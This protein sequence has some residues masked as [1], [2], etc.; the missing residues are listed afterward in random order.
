MIVAPNKRFLSTP[1]EGAIA[2]R[3]RRS[4]V[5]VSTAFCTERGSVRCE[6]RIERG[7]MYA[8][9]RRA[10]P[11][12]HA[13]ADGPIAPRKT[14]ILVLGSGWGAV[15]FVKS[16]D[17][18][19]FGDE[20]AYE[21]VV[22]SPRDYFVYTPL[23]PAVAS[24]TVD[25]ASIT[26]PMADVV[27]GKGVFVQATATKIDADA[28]L[29]S[30]EQRGVQ[31]FV[32]PEKCATAGECAISEREHTYALDLA[33]DV[34]VAAVGA[35]TSTYGIPGV[36]AHC[37]SIRTAE[38]SERL[39]ARFTASLE[40]A[41][42]ESVLE[43]YTAR[44]HM[45]VVVVGGGPT[46]VEVA[47][48][49]QEMLDSGFESFCALHGYGGPYWPTV[50][51]VSN[52]PTLL[53]TFSDRAS[54][55]AT[56]R[57]KDTGV[58][59]LLE[60]QVVEVTAEGVEIADVKTGARSFVDAATVVWA[61]G[62]E[63]TD[64]TRDVAAAFAA[65]SGSAARRGVV[66]D[67]FMRPVGGDDAVFWIG[68]AAATSVNPGEQLPPTAQV[69]R[70]QGEYVADLFNAGHVGLT[71]RGEVALAEK[72]RP[73]V[74]ESKGA[75]SYVG[76][77]AAVVDF[78]DGHTLTGATAGILWKA[79]ETVSQMT[80]ANKFAVLKDFARTAVHGHKIES[81]SESE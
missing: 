73:F 52:T 64:F 80:A 50:T 40:L 15:S 11:G 66:V 35:R 72:A 76:K 16:L 7:K 57:L 39:R 17:P 8:A 4:G 55:Y 45:S 44:C 60:K 19:L 78:P 6:A 10:T 31:K 47:A 41:C 56:E 65:N 36:D 68:D 63:A 27:R 9:A 3:P 75:M 48:E 34:L 67:D 22:A 74:Y 79:Y 42:R 59:E 61:G 69:A 1:P 37:I 5:R 70:A 32:D 43:T 29:V 13:H 25:A 53:A 62:V 49:L 58:I 18:A 81:G 23:L 38:D 51:L 71:T 46:G 21:L 28:R 12:I 30:F 26:T 24:G 77:A 2:P 54:A 20:G 33:Y 14:K